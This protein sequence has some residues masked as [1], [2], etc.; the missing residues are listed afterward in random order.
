MVKNEIKSAAFDAFG[1]IDFNN[2]NLAKNFE[3]MY[4]KVVPVVKDF[5][6]N[7]ELV[8]WG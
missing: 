4:D 2:K 8:P 6:K 3:E 5:M 1:H 7:M